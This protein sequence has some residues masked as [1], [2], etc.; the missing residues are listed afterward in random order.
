M[1]R[2]K[3][4]QKLVGNGAPSPSELYL[5]SLRPKLTIKDVL[6]QDTNKYSPSFGQYVVKMDR[7][8]TREVNPSVYAPQGLDTELTYFE[9]VNATDERG[10]DGHRILAYSTVPV[11]EKL[12]LPHTF[13]S[14]HG[15][16]TPGSKKKRPKY[17]TKKRDQVVQLRKSEVVE[18]ASMHNSD[19]ID[20]LSLS[21]SVRTASN[22]DSS[23]VSILRRPA[24]AVSLGTTQT[25]TGNN[26]ADVAT[27]TGDALTIT[28]NNSFNPYF[29][30]P[31]PY[32]ASSI[33]TF[34]SHI[35]RDHSDSL[36]EVEHHSHSNS[37]RN[38]PDNGY[39]NDQQ[40]HQ[41]IATTRQ[42]W[43]Q[44]DMEAGIIEDS[45][46]EFYEDFFDDSYSK[47]PSF[48]TYSDCGGNTDIV[49][50]Q[51]SNSSYQLTA[52]A[53]ALLLQRTQ[54]RQPATASSSSS[55]PISASDSFVDVKGIAFRP[56]TH[57]S[58][59]NCIV[60]FTANSTSI[61]RRP[62]TDHYDHM[63]SD[64]FERSL[65]DDNC[66][67]DTWDPLRRRGPDGGFLP[68]SMNPAPKT[69][70]QL[71]P[72]NDQINTDVISNDYYIRDRVTKAM[73]FCNGEIRTNSL[74]K[75]KTAAVRADERRMKKQ[76]QEHVSN[77]S[78]QFLNND[79]T[80]QQQELPQPHV[81]KDRP[82][83]ASVAEGSSFG[84]SNRN[85]FAAA[86]D[87]ATA[88]IAGVCLQPS[89]DPPAAL[90]GPIAV[91]P[92]LGKVH[93]VVDRAGVLVDVQT[94]GKAASGHPT[95][96]SSA[97]AVPLTHPTEIT[98]NPADLRATLNRRLKEKV[99]D[100]KDIPLLRATPTQ[101]AQMMEPISTLEAYQER[102]ALKDLFHATRGSKWHRRD[103]WRT[104]RPVSEW[105]GVTTNIAGYV[106]ELHLE[107]NGLRGTLPETIRHLTRLEVIHMDNNLIQGTR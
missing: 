90:G 31:R 84:Q 37:N 28:S 97:S 100:L 18:E 69:T 43:A 96:P 54:S 98:M 19:F 32:S 104:K 38:T 30:E 72:D 74:I 95:R 42:Q 39:I 103:H 92:G 85:I 33:V 93:M 25:G 20:K 63:Q 10:F 26:R 94:T 4:K 15:N 23:V 82:S 76:Y 75:E 2:H 9:T 5:Q 101:Q 6:L 8:R 7:S 16:Y 49:N 102:E 62:Q 60:T 11:D 73:R 77:T 45:G 83:S 64:H 24:T 40:N 86:V 78:A 59:A 89:L 41:Q 66:S 80:I 55:R 106:C 35:S 22:S 51:A 71:P 44:E 53:R 88:A 21:N 79:D 12:R 13:S 56:D 47:Q 65:A 70:S 46:S 99:D 36:V 3:H 57:Q 27:H 1:S 61:S 52:P 81:N 14:L 29:E 17:V 34:A 67:V 58:P 91:I 87:E 68:Y 50:D 48:P 107:N 105:Y